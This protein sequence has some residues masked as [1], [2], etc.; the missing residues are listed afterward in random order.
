MTLSVIGIK[1]IRAFGH[2]GVFDHEKI[3]GQEFIVDVELSVDISQAVAADDVNSTVDYGTVVVD[4]AHIVRSTRFDLIE[5]LANTIALH[6]LRNK[7][8]KSTIVTVHK[9]SAPI[10][11]IFSDVYVQVNLP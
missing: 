3:D 8:V 7:K 9:P 11:E 10:D 1:G 2:H 4:V 6:I 5:S